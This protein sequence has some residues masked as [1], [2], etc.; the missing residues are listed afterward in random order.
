MCMCWYLVRN[1]FIPSFFFFLPL[2]ILD[3]FSYCWDLLDLIIDINFRDVWNCSR[4]KSPNVSTSI[5]FELLSY[6]LLLAAVKLLILF[7]AFD[8]NSY[9]CR[10]RLMYL[11]ESL[12]FIKVG[13]SV[14]AW[15]HSSIVVCHTLI[16]PA[17]RMPYLAIWGRL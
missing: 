13:V 1:W 10:G 4:M 11:L 16:F 3:F 12:L 6:Y 17:L 2:Y 15:T 7:S 8:W 14:Q 9:F 5:S